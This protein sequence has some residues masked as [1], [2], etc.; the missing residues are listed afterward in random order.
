VGRR[1]ARLLFSEMERGN[2]DLLVEIEALNSQG[3]DES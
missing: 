2:V 1:T 3:F